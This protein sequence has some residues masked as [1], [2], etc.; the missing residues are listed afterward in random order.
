MKISDYILGGDDSVTLVSK[1]VLN[2]EHYK[3]DLLDNLKQL[4]HETFIH[5]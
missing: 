4:Y 1:V 3:K 5:L 2:S